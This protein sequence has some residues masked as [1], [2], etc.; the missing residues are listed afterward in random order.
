MFGGGTNEETSDNEG[1]DVESTSGE[2][3]N[4]DVSDGGDSVNDVPKDEGLD[5]SLAGAAL[6]YAANAKVG[7]PEGKYYDKVDVSKDLVNFT[8]NDDAA[9]RTAL[10]VGFRTPVPVLNDSPSGHD[11]KH[12]SPL[13]ASCRVLDFSDQTINK[14]AKALKPDSTFISKAKTLS[15][16]LLPKLNYAKQISVNQA[17]FSQ[18]VE[19]I[20]VYS[21]SRRWPAWCTSVGGSKICAQRILRIAFEVLLNCW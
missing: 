1:S 17:T 3:A 5:G 8:D 11:F 16:S 4:G 7:L 18:W 9:V 6:F 13:S 14:L 20:K 10:H 19:Q 21:Y 2:S 15:R 12:D